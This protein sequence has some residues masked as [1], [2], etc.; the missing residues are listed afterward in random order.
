MSILEAPP[1]TITLFVEET[2]PDSYGNPVRQPSSTSIEVQCLV[3]PIS[4][5]LRQRPDERPPR[6]YKVIVREAPITLFSRVI[7]NN[8]SCS[9]ESVI[10]RD[11]SP[12]TRHIEAVIRE[13]V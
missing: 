9:V 5:Q 11:D 1:H 13:E 3:T 2:T 7:W 12:T 6:R 10:R 8:Q 4:S